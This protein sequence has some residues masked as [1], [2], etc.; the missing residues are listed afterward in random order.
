MSIAAQKLLAVFFFLVG[1]AIWA[2]VWG[3][4]VYHLTPQWALDLFFYVGL[5]TMIVATVIV[6]YRH[7]KAGGH[8]R[9]D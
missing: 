6:I 8:L 3:Y 2:K 7:R 4:V 1:M 5:P 9:K